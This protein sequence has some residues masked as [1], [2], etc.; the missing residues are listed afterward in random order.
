MA[1]IKQNLQQPL[2][3]VAPS[4][5]APKPTANSQL[6]SQQDSQ[7]M[8][9][10]FEST[11]QEEILSNQSGDKNPKLSEVDITFLYMLCVFA[12]MMDV[13]ESALD[14]FAIAFLPLAPVFVVFAL[15]AKGLA[16][17]AEWAADMI[18][19]CRGAKVRYEV[20]AD[21]IELIPFI[22]VLPWRT[23]FLVLTI[24]MANS[25]SVML[26]AMARSKKILKK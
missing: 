14:G 4:T 18:L 26:Q 1:E 15:L 2:Q 24:H 25:E 9:D 3:T 23:A 7:D 16:T 22:N 12:D 20:L 8:A 21:F 13:A 5:Q 17:A 11:P 10:N 6:A 19:V